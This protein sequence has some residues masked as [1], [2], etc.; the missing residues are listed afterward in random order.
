MRYT[1]PLAVLAIMVAC[2]TYAWLQSGSYVARGI[3]ERVEQN[4]P[5]ARLALNELSRLE[6]PA[7]PALLDTAVNPD[8]QLARPARAEVESLLMRWAA[9]RDDPIDKKYLSVIEGIIQREE[10][11]TPSGRRW[12][13]RMGCVA[14]RLAE[15]T[16]PSVS[17][18]LVSTVER[19][20]D[21]S[22]RH[23]LVSD[24]PTPLKERQVAMS[25]IRIRTPAPVMAP[26]IAVAPPEAI[27]GEPTKPQAEAAPAVEPSPVSASG[28]PVAQTPQEEP[29]APRAFVADETAPL[30]AGPSDLAWRRPGEANGAG[31]DG[32]SAGNPLRQAVPEEVTKLLEGNEAD[33]LRLIEQ[34][35]T[36]RHENGAQ[37]LL[38]LAKD[39]APRVRASAI[40][41]LGTSPNRQLTEAA[42]RLA[43]RDEDPR[44]ARLAGELQKLLR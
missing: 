9:R 1:A 30:A 26:V 27:A 12:A 28:Q 11:L 17:P 22:Q 35:L 14:L 32:D 6:R 2:A 25:P 39:P 7:V 33:K 10:I 23:S 19:L 15:S 13:R 34:L 41:A 24:F 3:A 20:F 38:K 43:L 36:G 40:S 8:R 21:V 42:W 37:L 5:T 16:R 31:A 44:V 29:P 4:P 18:E